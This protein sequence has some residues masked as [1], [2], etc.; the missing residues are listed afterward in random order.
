LHHVV[1][2]RWSRGG[3]W[4][5]R[6]D[7]RAK[8]AALAIFLLLIAT[9][10]AAALQLGAAYFLLLIAALLWARLPL[11][12]ALGRSAI[13]LPFSLVFA[14]I[15]LLAGDTARAG[16]LLVRSYLSSLAVLVVISTTPMPRLLRGLESMGVPRFLLMVTQFLY[17]YLFVISEEAQHMRA[18]AIARGGMRRKAAA[19]ALAVLFA[20][21][22]ARADSIHQAMLARGFRGHFELLSANRF[23]WADAWLLLAAGGGAAAIRM[24]VERAAR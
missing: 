7:P 1:L 9:S 21:S 14:C 17:R 4:L 2:E 8:T 6:R 19:G 10:H 5:H 12:A 23:G 20:R 22:Y 3:S 24:A 18:A 13:V 11:V 16:A 15:S